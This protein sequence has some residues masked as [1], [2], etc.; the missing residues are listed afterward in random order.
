MW[1]VKATADDHTFAKIVLA[2]N[3][4]YLFLA[5]REAVVDLD[6]EEKENVTFQKFSETS[7]QLAVDQPRIKS[8][9]MSSKRV[10]E[11]DLELSPTPKR[12]ALEAPI[13]QPTR[14]ALPHSNKSDQLPQS[15]GLRDRAQ[16][17]ARYI[18]EFLPFG[19]PLHEFTDDELE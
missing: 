1:S 13:R 12:Q 5:R 2:N 11:E 19:K 8:V 16:T 17:L 18:S 14:P 7:Q 15:S 3:E 6:E 4:S 10:L 9:S